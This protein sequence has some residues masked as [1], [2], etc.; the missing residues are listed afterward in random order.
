MIPILCKNA[1]GQEQKNEAKSSRQK[2]KIHYLALFM[3]QLLDAGGGRGASE[4]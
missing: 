1:D 4:W 2:K 3:S